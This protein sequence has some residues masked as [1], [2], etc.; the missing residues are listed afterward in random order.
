MPFTNVSST[1]FLS[2]V[3]AAELTETSEMVELHDGKSLVPELWCE[4]KTNL[5]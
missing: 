1:Y 2:L 3:H 4:L 5:C